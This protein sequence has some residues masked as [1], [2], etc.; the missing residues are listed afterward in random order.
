MILFALAS[1]GQT[2]RA[3]DA[4][5]SD[6][7]A[8]PRIVNIYNF[9]R[10]TD[11]RL[12]DAEARLYEATEHQV[13]LFAKHRLPVTW[14]LQYDALINPKYQELL[15]TRIGPRDEIGAWWELPRQLVEAAG[16]TWRGDHDWVSTANIAFSPG[17]TPEERRKLVDVYMAQFKQVFVRYPRSVGSWYIDEVSLAYMSDRY[18][19][20][21]SCNC[22]DQIG[23]DGYTLWGGYWNQAYYPSR[24]NAYMP[25]QSA[26]GQINVP[27]FRMLGSDPIY[28]YGRAGAITSLEP[29]Y[30]HAGGSP[31]WVDWFLNSLTQTPCLAFGYAQAGQENSFGWPAMSKGLQSQAARLA[32]L[33]RAGAIRVETLAESG[34]WY[35]RRFPLTP[36]TSFVC[37]DDWRNEGRKTAWYNSRFYRANLLWDAGTL[38]IRDLH[39]F[40]ETRPSPV[41]DTALQ[42]STLTCA[43]LPVIEGRDPLSHERAGAFPVLL[44][45]DDT[46]SELRATG[47]PVVT[48]RGPDELFVSQPLRDGGDL[49]IVFEEDQMTCELTVA[50]GVGRKWAL[51]FVGQSDGPESVTASAATFGSATGTYDVVLEPD[52]G[53]FQRRDD[54]SV[55]ILSNAAGRITLNL[56]E[57]R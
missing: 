23:T 26:A 42:A 54:G 14:A 5:V 29:V 33:S 18:G 10:N 27:V 1:Y 31:E 56:G 57:S 52:C 20:V 13:E 28:Q 8:A 49:T 25:A 36:A 53:T 45:Q 16:I 12:Q 48:Q 40:D 38:S 4:D 51:D 35:R 46:E 22:K 15:K 19:I 6:A 50:D 2:A 47:P 3:A 34:E 17:Y 55:R 9:I 7:D 32:E 11:Y 24:L 39:R 44:G 43:T 21:A 41:H 30:G 37:L